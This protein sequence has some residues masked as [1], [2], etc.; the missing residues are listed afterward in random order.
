MQAQADL[1]VGAHF[2]D[3]ALLAHAAAQELE[4]L[5]LVD[6]PPVLAVDDRLVAEVGRLDH[7]QVDRL[8]RLVARRRAVK[9]TIQS[10]SR[11]DASGVFVQVDVDDAVVA[12]LQ[13]P[14]LLGMRQQQVFG[15]PPVEEQADTVDLHHL[16]AGELT[17]LHLGFLG[18]GDQL[19]VAVEIDEH[20][21]PVI[22]LGGDVLRDIAVGQQDF[23]IRPAIEV[24]PEVGVLDDLQ[25]VVAPD[26]GHG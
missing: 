1:A 26:C 8:A 7:Q 10:G 14:L 25:A 4:G 22:H 6:Q 12:L 15:Q 5:V 24:E 18:G 13:R 3:E 17:H 16:E 20:V 21:Q 19:V 23:A 2:L 9:V 11:G